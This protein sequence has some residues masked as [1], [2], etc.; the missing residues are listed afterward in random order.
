MDY[1]DAE[2]FEAPWQA[3]DQAALLTTVVDLSQVTFADSMLLNALLDARRRHD[4]HGRRFIL[5]G[6][7]SPRSAGFSTSAARGN[8][9]R[10]KIRT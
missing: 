9:S 4:S 8:T 1:E 5:L 10:W 3:A 6:P 7:S 2:D